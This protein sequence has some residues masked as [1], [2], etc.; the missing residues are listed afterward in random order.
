LELDLE[1]GGRFPLDTGTISILGEAKG[2][3]A[4]ERWNA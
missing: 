1:L 4:L 3:P 2:I